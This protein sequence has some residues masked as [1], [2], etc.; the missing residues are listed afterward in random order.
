DKEVKLN[1]I[2]QIVQ[3][4]PELSKA[5]AGLSGNALL[6]AITADAVTS[7]GKWS[8]ELMEGRRKRTE[9]L[10]RAGLD[11]SL[12]ASLQTQIAFGSEDSKANT[13]VLSSQLEGDNLSR[14]VLLAIQEGNVDMKSL[15]EGR[16][17]IKTVVVEDDE[18]KSLFFK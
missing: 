9:L 11:N 6:S 12:L 17:A 5:Y 4:T 7:G 3:E 13:L 8:A 14:A 18:T 15:L 1:N 2:D 16:K 10:Q